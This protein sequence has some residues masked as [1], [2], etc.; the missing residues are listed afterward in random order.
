MIQDD[1]Y[2][3]HET[4]MSNSMLRT[5]DDSMP[6]TEASMQS[7]K[8]TNYDNGNAKAHFDNEREVN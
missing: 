1:K 4:S 3:T 2:R 5:K 6:M 8:P 7:A